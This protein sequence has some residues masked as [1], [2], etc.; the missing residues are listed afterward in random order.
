M[1]RRQYSY[2]RQ[3]Q[4]DQKLFDQKLYYY[5]T[6]NSY[7]EKKKQLA[8]EIKE[9]REKKNEIMKMS[10]ECEDILSIY[11]A[12]LN[13]KIFPNAWRK[14]Y[15][16]ENI[17]T[18]LSN[19]SILNYL[20]KVKNRSLISDKYKLEKAIKII[21]NSKYIQSRLDLSINNYKEYSGIYSNV[22]IEIIPAKNIYSNFI[23]KGESFCHIFFN[24]DKTEIKRKNLNTNEN[25]EKIRIIID[26]QLKSF[27]ELFLDC[28][29]IES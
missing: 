18:N 29:C 16:N 8:L 12:E 26:Y 25:I 9:T 23:N 24:N 11:I 2:L 10:K 27:K 15:G 19:I 4:I 5:E 7:D 20:Q 14:N 17:E 21:N 1:D 13:A 3:L 28:K 6:K 22:E